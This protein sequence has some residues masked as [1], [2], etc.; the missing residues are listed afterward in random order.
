MNIT[1]KISNIEWIQQVGD[2]SKVVKNV[3]YWVEA[4]DDAGNMGYTWG[5]VQLD[6][7]N[8]S[9]FTEYPSITEEQALEWLKSALGPTQV[10]E[11]EN[12]ITSRVLNQD[13]M[14][15]RGLGLPWQL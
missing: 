8:P 12:Y 15:I 4:K 9:S 14:D 13:P 3:H 1:W 10:T 2:H 7:S 6:I 5:N 11:I